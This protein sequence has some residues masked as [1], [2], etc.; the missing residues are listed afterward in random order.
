MS[1]EPRENKKRRAL[2]LNLKKEIKSH[3]E[4]LSYTFGIEV[5]YKELKDQIEHLK[6][7]YNLPSEHL[8]LFFIKKMAFGSWI[9]KNR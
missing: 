3:S 2:Q 6:W 5:Y 7:K 4:D 1:A 8:V 9:K